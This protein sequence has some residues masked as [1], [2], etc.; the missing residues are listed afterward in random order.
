M[1]FRSA[2][3]CPLLVAVLLL[4]SVSS[5]MT[6]ELVAAPMN[7]AFVKYMDDVR[8]KRALPVNDS[9]PRALPVE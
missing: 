1:R 7:P 8:A 9:P 2:F 5:G 4:S 6:A 3:A